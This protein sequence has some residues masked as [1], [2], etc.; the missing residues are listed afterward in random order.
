LY[1][2]WNRFGMSGADWLARAPFLPQLKNLDLRSCSIG[3]EGL[4]A[5]SERNAFG[6]LRTLDLGDNELDGESVGMLAESSSLQQLSVL[7]L[8]DNGNA[9]DALPFLPQAR[10]A[11]S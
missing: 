1:L 11:G 10:F 6:S 7:S 3:P 9:W 2:S 8:Q 5:F 4:L